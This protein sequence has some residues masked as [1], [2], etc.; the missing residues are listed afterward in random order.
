[1]RLDIISAILT[2]YGCRFPVFE[3]QNHSRSQIIL[4]ALK[5]VE[6]LAQLDKRINKIIT[7][8]LPDKVLINNQFIKWLAQ[9]LGQVYWFID[10][11]LYVM[12]TDDHVITGSTSQNSNT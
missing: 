4:E 5:I 12:T 3:C 9:I 10:P 8:K 11:K 6:K 7:S 1:V 2:Q